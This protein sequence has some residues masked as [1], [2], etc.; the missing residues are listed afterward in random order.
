[1]A[2][3]SSHTSEGLVHAEE[4]IAFFRYYIDHI[5]LVMLS[6]I[7]GFSLP[8]PRDDVIVSSISVT[9]SVGR[10]VAFQRW[11]LLEYEDGIL[12][13]TIP[14]R[15]QNSW[16]S[17]H[18]KEGIFILDEMGGVQSRVGQCGWQH[19]RRSEVTW[20]T[21]SCSFAD[22][23]NG[24]IQDDSSWA[25]WKV[26]KLIK[27]HQ[28]VECTVDSSVYIMC[29]WCC[30]RCWEGKPCVGWLVITATIIHKPLHT[31]H[32]S[33]AFIMKQIWICMYTITLKMFL[34]ILIN[35]LY[36]NKK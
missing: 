22:K 25:A 36:S 5:G 29:V 11:L 13:L 26:L 3:F 17:V 7:Q 8:L 14:Q 27:C 23:E 9:L 32:I 33:F 1:M 10:I 28:P 16:I 34:K 18:L 31:L 19:G 15:I 20:G 2:D 30:M 24:M 12:G 4:R 6:C 21:A 35:W